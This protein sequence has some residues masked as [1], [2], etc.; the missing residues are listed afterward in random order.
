MDE[1]LLDRQVAALRRFN[2]FY[3]QKIG[4]LEEGYLKSPFSLAEGRVLYELAQRRHA[5]ATAL[6]RDLGLDQ[7]YLSRILAR[8][9]RQGLIAKTPSPDDGRQTQLSLTAAGEAAYAPLE[10]ASRTEIGALIERL[11]PSE[12]VRV[13]EAV[14][15]VER[16]VGGGPAPRV[17]YLLRPLQPG[18]IG[19][20]THRHG[21]LYAQ[22]QGWNEKIETFT[23]E[24]LAK[25]LNGHDPKRE[26]GWIAEREG[27]IVGSV[28]LMRESDEEG[29]L[30]L[31]Y[32]E[33]SARGLGI[34][35]RLVEECVTMARRVGYRRLV[36]WT[37]AILVPA[38]RIYQQAG[39]RLVRE[40]RHSIFGPELVGEDWL[41][42]L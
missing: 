12:R 9:E 32:V 25:F 24:V 39:F 14:E 18:D 40:E 7:G 27:A 42:E 20:V 36:L 38:R 1:S 5:T 10:A 19:W 35:K 29:R 21:V 34:G 30:R 41:L 31:L 37:H 17:P 33:H 13:T 23:A 22:D 2:R 15:V 16:L 4:V 26:R 11:S 3:T 8:F 6:S 28:F